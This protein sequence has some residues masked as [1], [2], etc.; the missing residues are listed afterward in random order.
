MNAHHRLV[1]GLGKRVFICD[2]TFYPAVG[3][4]VASDRWVV[5]GQRALPAHHQCSLVQRLDLHVHWGTAAH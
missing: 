4:H 2:V 3:D 1:P 5:D